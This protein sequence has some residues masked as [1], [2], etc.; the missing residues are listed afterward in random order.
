ME[1]GC[2]T[3][4]ENMTG[5]GFLESTSDLPFDACIRVKETISFTDSIKG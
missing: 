3:C 5:A 1:N 4:V 2:D